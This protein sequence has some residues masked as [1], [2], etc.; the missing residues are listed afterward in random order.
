M[1]AERFNVIGLGIP[2]MNGEIV[3]KDV[4][5]VMLTVM[6]RNVPLAHALAGGRRQSIVEKFAKVSAQAHSYVVD[7]KLKPVMFTAFVAAFCIPAIVA[8]LLPAPL[9]GRARGVR[10]FDPVVER[11]REVGDAHQEQHQHR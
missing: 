5:T 6:T 2:G 7:G 8:E 11:A 3:L 4:D 10:Q 9:Y 1:I